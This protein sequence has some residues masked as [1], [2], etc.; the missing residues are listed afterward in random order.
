[1][2][3]HGHGP[4]PFIRDEAIESFYHMRENLSTNFR[5]TKAAGRYAFL[6]LGVVPGLL[7]FGAY[8]FAG[9]LDFVAK[10]RN[11]SVWRQH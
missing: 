10:R 7:L 11:E 3:G 9:Q 5:Y 6:A 1:M 2:A 8:K 4:H